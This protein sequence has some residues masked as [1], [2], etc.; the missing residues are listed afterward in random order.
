MILPLYS[1]L[2][3]TTLECC[4]EFCAPQ[5]NED[6]EVPE[7]IQQRATKIS[8]GLEH[9]SHKEKLQE[10]GLFSSKKR[11]QRRDLINTYKYLKEGC[12]EDGARLFSGAQRQDKE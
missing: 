3:R 5:Y 6:K 9:L 2:I 1:A 7:R 11:R 4:I 8:R 10:L 12:Q